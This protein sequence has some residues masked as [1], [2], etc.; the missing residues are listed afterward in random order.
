MFA[1]EDGS[2]DTDNL[3]RD[4]EDEVILPSDHDS[5]SQIECEERLLS[6]DTKDDI[7]TDRDKQTKWIKTNMHK[8]HLVF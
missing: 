1:E 5:D 2:G 4:G 7:F 8:R 3:C 6:F